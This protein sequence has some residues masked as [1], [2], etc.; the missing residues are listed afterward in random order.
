MGSL[1]SGIFGDEEEPAPP[2][3]PPVI[4]APPIM[5]VPDDR[6][7]QET[8]RRSISRQLAR[9]GRRSTILSDDPVTG[10]TLG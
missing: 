10:E 1:F 8:R 9:R 7:M 2:P 6:A 4:E 5:P 3:P